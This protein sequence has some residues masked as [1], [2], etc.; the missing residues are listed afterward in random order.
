MKCC[1]VRCLAI[2][3]SLAPSESIVIIAHLKM[4]AMAE[5]FSMGGSSN[6]NNTVV[7]KR[8]LLWCLQCSTTVFPIIRKFRWLA[9]GR[10]SQKWGNCHPDLGAGSNLSADEQLSHQS[11]LHGMVALLLLTESKGYSG[12]GI[13]ESA[14]LRLFLTETVMLSTRA[15]SILPSLVSAQW[16]CASVSVVLCCTQCYSLCSDYEGCVEGYLLHV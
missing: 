8:N 6:R 1:Y 9:V 3:L 2:L 15:P 14:A 7:W 10:S 5:T 12:A 4:L 13:I 16:P 11:I